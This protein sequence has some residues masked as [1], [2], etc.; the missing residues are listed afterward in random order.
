MHVLLGLLQHL[1]Q[2]GGLFLVFLGEERVGDALV[3]ATASS[4]D[5]V[6][7]MKARERERRLVEIQMARLAELESQTNWA[8]YRCT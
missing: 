8:T 5:T 6:R 2:V 1:D 7:A 3:V 4:A